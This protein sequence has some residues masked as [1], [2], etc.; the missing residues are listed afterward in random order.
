MVLDANIN[1]SAFTTSVQAAMSASNVDSDLV[2]RKFLEL[3]GRAS[4]ARC[5][6]ARGGSPERRFGR[7][8]RQLRR[9]PIPAPKADPPRLTYSDLLIRIFTAEGAPAGWPD[10][11]RELDEAA[12]GDDSAMAQLV[13]GPRRS[14]R[15]LSTPPPL[16]VRRQAHPGQTWV[17]RHGPRSPRS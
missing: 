13:Q 9:G 3:C 4:P 15:E 16:A 14:S 11:A 12:R 8:L 17:P 7:L 1:P 10:F 6:L 5:A 2:I